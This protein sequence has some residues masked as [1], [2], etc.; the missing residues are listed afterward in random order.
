MTTA[1][2]ASGRRRCL[3]VGEVSRCRVSGIHRNAPGPQFRVRRPAAG[4]NP[5]V[6][7][8]VCEIATRPARRFVLALVLGAR[9]AGSAV[10]RV[11]NEG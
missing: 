6:A 4:R 9:L 10:T 11:R 7:M 2:D 8:V 5:F 3:A 1:D